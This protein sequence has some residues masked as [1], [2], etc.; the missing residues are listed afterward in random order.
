MANE[1]HK[2]LIFLKRR[3]GMT[4]QE[5]RD[6]YEQRHRKVIGK[7]L[8]GVSYYARRYLDPLPHL[9]T[10]VIHEPEFDVVTELWFE[11]RAAF[12]G[13][14]KMV[15]EGVLPPDVFE[16]EQHVFDRPRTRYFTVTESVG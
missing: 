6:Y 8:Q 11:S 14:V 7:Y 10:K 13:L 3:P 15:S 2:I 5:F 9:D 12:D 4:V 16:D 1:V